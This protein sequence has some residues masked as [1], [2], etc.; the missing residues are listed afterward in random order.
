MTDGTEFDGVNSDPVTMGWMQG[1]PVPQGS[2]INPDHADHMRFPKT[3]WSFSNMRKFVPTARIGRGEGPVSALPFA[4]RDD[5]DCL[6]VTPLEGSASMRLDESLTANFTDGFLVMHRGE[7]I[8]ERYFGVS[9]PATTHIAF[10]ITKSFYGTIAEMLVEEGKLDPAKT[11]AHYLPELAKSGF[12]DATLR[13]VLDMR[14]ALDWSEVYDDNESDI[15]K[16]S[17]AVRMVPRHADYS[18]AN[19]MYS[20]L[21]SVRRDH[22]SEHGDMYNYRTVNTE[23]IGWLIGRIEGKS[24]DKVLSE[25]I[26]QPLGM[27]MDADIICDPA[28][29]P[30]AGGGMNSCLRD[31]ARFGEM[32]RCGG[33]YDGRRVVPAAVVE[34]ITAGSGHP[35]MHRDDYPSLPGFDYSSQWW[36]MN[37]DHGCFTARGIHGQAI[38]IDPAAEMVIARF[39]SMPV[40]ANPASDPLSLATYRAIADHLMR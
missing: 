17:A 14:T 4:L 21:P 7:V 39:A 8:F 38:W 15:I 23:V 5:L 26:W 6:P 37:D 22:G 27:E 35:G 9:G 29:V 32:M 18:G 10:S 25:R 31:M 40:A 2:L 24:T 30:F 28:L 19:D 34:R 13:D 11:V 33:S 20:Y 12:G 1:A 3:R 36:H 16:F